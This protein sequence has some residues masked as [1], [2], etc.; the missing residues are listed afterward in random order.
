MT[1]IREPGSNPPPAPAASEEGA[2]LYLAALSRVSDLLA[3]ALSLP[4]LLERIM[5]ECRTL[6]R[7]E[8][9]SLLLYDEERGDLYFE[10]AL[11]EAG[12]KVKSI[13]LALGEGAAGLCAMRRETVI[14]NA[15][16]SDPRHSKK[17]DQAS[18]FVTRNVLAV[19]LLARGERLVGVLEAINSLGREEFSGED[20][21]LLKLFAD[22]AA[23]VI[24]N[25]RL[26]E[27]NTENERLA[28]IGVAVAGIS[29]YVKNIL[30]GIQ[31]ATSLIRY[32]LD[33]NQPEIIADTWPIL[34]RSHQRIILLVKEM[35]TYSRARQP[36]LQPGDLNSLL[37]EIAAQLQATAAESRVRLET[38]LDPAL[39]PTLFDPLAIHDAALNL[40]ANAIEACRER[41]GG[42][43]ILSTAR[44]ADGSLLLRVEDDG[45]GIPPDVLPRLFRPFFS[46][47]G[48]KGTGLG[49]AVVKKVAEEHGGRAEAGNRP[50]GGARFEISLPP[51]SLDEPF[52]APEDFD[53]S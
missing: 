47:K 36:D 29:H 27:K 33:Q 12:E 7:A 25:A 4:A 40:A 46:T 1:P 18:D 15:A 30:A 10:V 21:R 3:A 32:A 9:S 8:A 48:S 11:G 49:L 14:I 37:T 24:E 31:G 50:E 39:P 43:V 23:L 16:A 51:R 5:E 17:A 35:L 45:P 42:E 2:R 34:E 44:A 20:A 6:V 53:L 13:R 19:P 26:I 38:R 52:R 22:P 41:G 28:A